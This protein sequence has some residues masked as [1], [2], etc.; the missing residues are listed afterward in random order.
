M[1]KTIAIALGVLVVLSKAWDV[2]RICR[3]EC[4]TCGKPR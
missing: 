4:P 1:R 3:D 2:A